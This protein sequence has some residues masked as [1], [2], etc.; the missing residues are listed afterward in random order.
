M[1]TETLVNLRLRIRERSDQVQTNQFV[2]DAELNRYI[3]AS[4]REYYDIVL[5]S[6]ADHYLAAPVSFT[7]AAGV[8]SYALSNLTSF[9][10]LRGIDRVEGTE[11]I[12]IRRYNNQERNDVR[13]LS[14]RVMG[15]TI[16]FQPASAAAGSYRA[17]YIPEPTALTSDSDTV[18]G[19]NG[20]EEWI[21]CD[22]ANKISAKAEEDV[23]P[24]VRDRDR[25]AERIHKASSDR[26]EGDAETI[27]DVFNQRNWDTWGYW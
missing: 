24:F 10:R 2:S 13:K 18:D 26:D 27:A 21:V 17:W 1:A 20:W 5:E 9:Y 4:Y 25:I 15:S 22:V 14:Y 8:S 7:L 3:N 6:H 23:G 11:Y 19:F 16:Y 12:S